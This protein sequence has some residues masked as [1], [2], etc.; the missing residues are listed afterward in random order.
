[1]TK[2]IYYKELSYQIIGAAFTVHRKLGS[3]LPEHCYQ[4]ALQY[5]FHYNHVPF[6]SQQKFEVHYDNDYCGH[7]LTD[8]IIDNKIILELIHSCASLRPWHTAHP[9]HTPLLRIHAPAAYYRQG[10]RACW[11]RRSS[12]QCVHPW[13]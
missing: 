3:A 5:E 9:V 1:M 10:W 6:T 8:L 13:T 7:F 4:R 12:F 11:K 2:E